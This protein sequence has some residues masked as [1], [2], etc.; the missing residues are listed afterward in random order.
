[1]HRLNS[2]CCAL[3]VLFATSVLAGGQAADGLTALFA[4][5][6]FDLATDG[7]DFLL[8][9][10]N[11]ASFLL[12]G[13]LHG[14][15][16]TQALLQA[17]TPGLG[18]GPRLVITEMSPW[19]ANRLFATVP[20]SSGVRLRGADIEEVQPHLLIRDLAASNPEN[21]ALQQMSELVK[22][23]YRP[24]LAEGLL[25][26]A[27]QI[28][29]VKDASPGG[30]PLR[31][32]L[33]RT[34]EVEADRSRPETS[35]Q[36][37]SIRRERVMKDF[38]LTHYRQAVAAG[39]KPKVVAAFGRNPLHRGLDRR[40]VSTLGN[41]VAEFALVEGGELFNM[42]LF[43]AGGK[44]AL[45]GVRDFDERKD[46]PAFDF[47]ASIA[48]YTT[49]VF[50]MKPLR[51]PLRNIPVTARTPA[52]TSLLYWADSYDAVVCYRNVTPLGAR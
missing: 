30:V 31:T 14:D 18:E 20:A 34:L 47:L 2:L 43:A 25:G 4:R 41:F 51:E 48:R 24:A 37:A 45:G 5:N 52:Q 33:V 22:N 32:L 17:L 44:I 16:E 15:N 50:D 46:D 39:T 38:F 10:V 23:G 3:L 42:A 8:K 12:V 7:R 9:A 19:A 35:G 36:A 1:M 29:E 40:G 27:L 11:R 13:G 26:L 28:G 49:T 6:Q 21:R